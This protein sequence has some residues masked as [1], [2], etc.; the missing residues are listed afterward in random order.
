MLATVLAVTNDRRGGHSWGRV[1]PA[2]HG[3]AR[4]RRG[5]GGITAE[6]LELASHVRLW[7]HARYAT[8]GAH[9]VE[10]AHPFQIGSVLGAHNGVLSN[11]ADLNKKYKR[12]FQ[13]DSMHLIAHIAEG[14][15][16]F[17]DIYGYGALVW[18][19][20]GSPTIYLCRMAD[21]E[22]AIAETAGGVV[23]SSAEDH[24]ELALTA[25][26][27][28][29]DVWQPATGVVLTVSRGRIAETDERI[30]LGQAPPRYAWA[31][32][33]KT[34]TLVDVGRGRRARRALTTDALD[35]DDEM[36]CDLCDRLV[37]IYAAESYAGGW[38]HATCVADAE[39][40]R[41]LADRPLTKGRANG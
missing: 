37:S 21:G 36:N 15:K 12:N 3:K 27:L 32:N 38:A 16:T 9:T 34:S 33:G 13:V 26:G 39:A 14:R 28:A 18:Q 30:D 6:S 1:A 2:E 5:L 7:A 4:I 8:H 20:D 23:W 29:G 22:L 11:H 10:N 35:L 24:L 19:V 31:S 40:D 25:S 17:G 41:L